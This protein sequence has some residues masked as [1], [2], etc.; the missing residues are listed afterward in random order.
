VDLCR[1]ILFMSGIDVRRL[2]K[3]VS[4]RLALGLHN[5]IAVRPV[6]HKITVVR[7]RPTGDLVV[8]NQRPGTRGDGMFQSATLVLGPPL[9]VSRRGF[10]HTRSDLDPVS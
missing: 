3:T 10:P 9:S 1:A 6:H 7:D 5:A 8:G 4:A 2:L